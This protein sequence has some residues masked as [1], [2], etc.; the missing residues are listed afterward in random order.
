MPTTSP[1]PIEA[2]LRPVTEAVEK[3]LPFM[4]IAEQ[5]IETACAHAP[6]ETTAKR[7]WKSFTLL[8]PIAGLE[9]PLLYRVH[10]REILARLATGCATHPATDAEIMSVV[11]AV[12]KQ[13]PLRASAM[14]LLFRLAERSA[15]EIAAI[16]SQAMDLAAYES[17]HGSEADALEEDARRRLNQPWRG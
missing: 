13:V 1:T 15:P 11:V 2:M 16:C 4:A 14:C 6:D 5:E 9:Q 3:Q 8:R 17:V 7:L 12:S 10:C